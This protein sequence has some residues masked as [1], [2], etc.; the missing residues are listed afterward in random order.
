MIAVTVSCT[1]IIVLR[2]DR[3][4]CC[5]CPASSAPDARYCCWVMPELF[6]GG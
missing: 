3:T 2:T 1:S 4:S 6:L 5:A